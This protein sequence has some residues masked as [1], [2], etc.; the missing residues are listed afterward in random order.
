MIVINS[1]FPNSLIIKGYYDLIKSIP[2]IKR[3]FNMKF[4]LNL[5]LLSCFNPQYFFFPVKI[6]GQ[7]TSSKVIFKASLV[8]YPI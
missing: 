5:F 3:S 6:E 7:R 4:L 8:H 2:L 1:V